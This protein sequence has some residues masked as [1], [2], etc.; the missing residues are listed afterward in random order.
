MSEFVIKFGRN[1]DVDG[2]E[3]IIDMGGDY[4]GWLTA[5]IVPRVVSND[6]DDAATGTG[7]RTVVVAG[8][9]ANYQD[10]SE[11]VTMNGTTPVNCVNSYIRVFRAYVATAGSQMNNDGTIVVSD[12]ETG[13]IVLAQIP[14]ALG[15]TLQCVYTVPARYRRAKITKWWFQPIVTANTDLTMAILTRDFGTNSWRTREWVQVT[16]DGLAAHYRD[17]LPYGISLK[18]KTDV[19]MR[20]LATTTSN[21]VIS[22]SFDIG[23][24]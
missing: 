1:T 4:A 10:Q 6:T 16:S 9:D 3:D 17:M 15:Q 21:V 14:E 7:A 8:L 20:C 11:T 22:G 19:R 2:A 18:P 24:A 12:S 23:L 5:P 13:T